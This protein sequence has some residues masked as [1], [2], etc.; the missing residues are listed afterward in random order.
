M[1]EPSILFAEAA[2]GKDAEEFFQSDLGRFILGRCQQE[3]DAAHAEL[4]TVWPWR[5]SRIRALQTKA[6]RART[7]VGW[8]GDL[9]TAGKA[10]SD[11]LEQEQSD[12]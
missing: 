6:W 12:D 4:E 10:A 3:I 9:V 8:L 7:V 5:K 2:L 11:I 1:D